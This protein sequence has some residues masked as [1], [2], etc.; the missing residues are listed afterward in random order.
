VFYQV[1][2]DN[3]SLY[4]DNGFDLLKL[5][6]KALVPLAQFTTTGKR[7]ENLRWALNR[8]KREGLEF[9]VLEQPLSEDDWA[10]LQAISER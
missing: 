5:G 3:L 2:E 7:N 9:Q 10:Q 1:S 6:E 8:A 4:H